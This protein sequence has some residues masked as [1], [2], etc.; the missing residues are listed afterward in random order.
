[1]DVF[2]IFAQISVDGFV[3][4]VDGTLEVGHLYVNPVFFVWRIGVVGGEGIAWA[5]ETIALDGV[6][7]RIALLRKV[8]AE[9]ASRLRHVGVFVIARNESESAYYNG[10]QYDSITLVH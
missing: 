4:E 10:N 2:E 3:G 6:D 7:G 9:I 8:N 1:M 5:F